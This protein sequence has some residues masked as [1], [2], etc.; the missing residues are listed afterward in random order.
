MGSSRG[1][2]EDML[3]ETRRRMAGID[4]HLDMI[5]LHFYHAFDH[6]TVKQASQNLDP[7]LAKSTSKWIVEATRGVES[8][9]LATNGEKAT[10][11]RGGKG[12]HKKSRAEG[13]ANGEEDDQARPKTR[14]G[15]HE[16]LEQRLSELREERRRRQ[17]AVD[18]RKGEQARTDD[19][20]VGGKP[21]IVCDAAYNT[22]NIDDSSNVDTTDV[23]EVGRMVFDPKTS[24]LPFESLLGTKG[25]KVKRLRAELRK[26]EAEAARL[27][28]A[29]ASGNGEEMR[30]EIAMEKALKRARGERVHDDSTKLRKAQKGLELKRKRGKDKWEER[31]D[32]ANKKSV[33]FQKERKD[34]LANRP[35]KNKNKQ[36]LRLGFEGSRSGF[37]NPE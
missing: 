21:A 16:R 36:K 23:A 33:Q 27:Q 37:L 35:T 10:G 3:V 28:K 29:E 17:S 26:K 4:R 2:G 19:G 30:K 32:E 31:K 7:A 15:L 20:I 9:L 18:K 24:S 5:P 11:S 13:S 6:P 12:R 25:A 22:G 34:N 8:E 1:A 14:E